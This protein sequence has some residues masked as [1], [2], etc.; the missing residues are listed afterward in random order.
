[1]ENLLFCV[2]R[3][4]HFRWSFADINNN[5]EQAVMDCAVHDI[6]SASMAELSCRDAR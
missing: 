6:Q 4:I 3:S 5:L 1:M 2:T